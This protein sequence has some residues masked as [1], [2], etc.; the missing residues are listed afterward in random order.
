MLFYIKNIY[1]QDLSDEELLPP[2]KF[3][4]KAMIDMGW[5]VVQSTLESTIGEKYWAQ[6]VS[7]LGGTFFLLLISNLSGVFPG[8]EPATASMSFTFAGSIIIFL[9][10]NYL[11]YFNFYYLIF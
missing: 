4:F 9:Y 10:F 1:N 6:F 8:F 2:K 3:G 7:V 5:S 11:S